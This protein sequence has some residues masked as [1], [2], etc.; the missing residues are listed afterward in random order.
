[1]K[2]IL[3]VASAFIVGFIANAQQKADDIIKVKIEK[4]D[5]GKIKQSVPVTTYFEIT[6]T[7]DKPIVFKSS[8]SCLVY[9]VPVGL[10]GLLMMIAFVFFVITFSNSLIGGSAKPFTI[11]L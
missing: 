2:K 9:K 4:F 5:F 3:L 10:L 1:M 6:N 7:S 8:S 11:P